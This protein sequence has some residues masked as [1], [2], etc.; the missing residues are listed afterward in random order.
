MDPYIH[1]AGGRGEGFRIDDIN[2][3]DEFAWQQAKIKAA[4]EKTPKQN[5]K[6]HHTLKLIKKVF[7]KVFRRN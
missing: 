4:L 1:A 7:G 2:D 3:L 6:S 5:H